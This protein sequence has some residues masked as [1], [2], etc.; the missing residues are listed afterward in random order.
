MKASTTSKS[1]QCAQTEKGNS[2][3]IGSDKVNTGWKS[4]NEAELGN[5]IF[6]DSVNHDD[7][8][9]DD[10]NDKFYRFICT[11]WVQWQQI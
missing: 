6:I 10:T 7:D 11:K 9:D 3:Q 5:K 4:G 2:N 8:D 1:L